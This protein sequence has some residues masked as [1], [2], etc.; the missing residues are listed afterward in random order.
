MVKSLPSMQETQVWSLGQEDT[1]EK[2]MPTCS[3]ILAWRIL[4]TEEPGRLQSMDSKE[5]D[6]T[7]QRTLSL[8]H[9][10]SKGLEIYWNQMNLGYHVC[11]R[12]EQRWFHIETA[13]FTLNFLWL[14]LHLTTKGML[15]TA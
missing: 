5:L 14:L 12:E 7:K 15:P 2:G 9:F 10:T 1:L 6:T 11:N 3:S 13:S 8:F 4:W